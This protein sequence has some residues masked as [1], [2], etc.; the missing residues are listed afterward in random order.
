MLAISLWARQLSRHDV[1]TVRGDVLHKN[2]HGYHVQILAWTTY[3]LI[4]AVLQLEALTRPGISPVVACTD[5]GGAGLRDCT[6]DGSAGQLADQ[7]PAD[8]QRYQ[9]RQRLYPELQ[10][11]SCC[12]GTSRNVN[13]ATE[14]RCT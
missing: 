8:G 4:S 3:N 1:N 12:K 13:T 7:C 2:I 11:L 9:V 5:N 14:V 6:D 10:F